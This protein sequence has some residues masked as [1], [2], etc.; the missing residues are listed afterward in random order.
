M[1]DDF[2]AGLKNDWRSQDSEF[3]A[4]KLRLSR[5]RWAARAAIAAEAALTLSG[6]AVGFWFASIALRNHD[7]FFGLSA[8]ML[9]LVV[10]LSAVV[11]L[12]LRRKL[13]GD[14]GETPEYVLHFALARTQVV[15][16][17]L[18][19]GLLSAAILLL[20]VAVLWVC[21]FVGWI[22][23]RYPLAL[24]SGIWIGA[25]AIAVAW[26]LWRRRRNDRERAQCRRLL[27]QFD[28][29]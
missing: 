3:E 1:T 6:M 27:S 7:L 8:F 2:L 23:H 11:L 18:K 25:S 15:D 20:F 16:R 26:F 12:G 29:E 10:P 9:L 28:V 21:A 22:S 14:V 24:L 4:V 17:I 19:I 5:A 13:L